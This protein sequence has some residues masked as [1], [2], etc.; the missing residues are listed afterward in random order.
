MG[1]KSYCMVLHFNVP[2]SPYNINAQG[3]SG[4]AGVPQL[5]CCQTQLSPSYSNMAC[6][7]SAILLLPPLSTYIPPVELTRFGQPSLSSHRT[8]SNMC[9]HISPIMPLP[10][11]INVRHQRTCGRPSYGRKGAGPV[12][13]S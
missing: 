5:R 12:H 8:V 10:Y 2:L 6:C 7:V 9:M 11:S 13:I 4:S 3:Y 1:I